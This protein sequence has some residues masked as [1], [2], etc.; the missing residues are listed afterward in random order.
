MSEKD[1]LPFLPTRHGTPMGERNERELRAQVGPE[2]IRRVQRDNLDGSMTVLHT[3]GGAF[4]YVTTKP[5]I[6]ED[7][8]VDFL[9]S[10]SLPAVKK[11]EGVYYDDYITRG[12]I[13]PT[14]THKVPNCDYVKGPKTRRYGIAENQDGTISPKTAESV[15]EGRDDSRLPGSGHWISSRYVVTW[16]G[17]IGRGRFNNNNDAQY[18]AASFHTV[19]IYD[20]RTKTWMDTVLG[21]SDPQQALYD[22]YISTCCVCKTDD[23]DRIL[24]VVKCLYSPAFSPLMLVEDYTMNGELIRVHSSTDGELSCDRRYSYVRTSGQSW[25][26]NGHVLL[27]SVYENGVFEFREY[28]VTCPPKAQPITLSMR[29]IVV[30]FSALTPSSSDYQILPDPPGYAK[31]N[32]IVYAYVEYHYTTIGGSPPNGVTDGEWPVTLSIYFTTK[33]VIDGVVV[34]SVTDDVSV[35]GVNTTVAVPGG[36]AYSRQISTGW[37]WVKIVATC[38][39]S[40][41]LITHCMPNDT[42]FVHVSTLGGNYIDGA[43]PTLAAFVRLVSVV[44]D[45]V[46]VSTSPN[47]VTT[48]DHYNNSSGAWDPFRRKALFLIVNPDTDFL[49]RRGAVIAGTGAVYDY[50]PQTILTGVYFSADK[51]KTVRWGDVEPAH[52]T[53]WPQT[54]FISVSPFGARK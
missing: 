44:N 54:F 32:K 16:G 45:E 48:A 23:G 22:Y 50:A 34:H 42:N 1:D 28:D 43:D 25:G 27:A 37:G 24:R 2:S 53:I 19:R 6:E 52:D 39:Y 11:V 49:T 21:T 10:Y 5:E 12:L 8:W 38:H 17:F 9:W 20:R 26:E 14:T 7:I 31:D 33:F 15:F 47:A 35:S 30:P 29:G 51:W 46:F 18:V 41:T 36:W 3:R 40:K 4:E 13:S